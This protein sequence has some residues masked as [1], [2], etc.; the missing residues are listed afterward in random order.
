M[1]ALRGE[2]EAHGAMIAL[3]TPVIAGR[4]AERGLV[5][6][7]GGQRPCASPPLLS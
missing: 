6:E 7:T 3:K 2:A 4:A 1:L 5:I